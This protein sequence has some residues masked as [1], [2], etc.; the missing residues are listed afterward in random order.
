MVGIFAIAEM[1]QYNTIQ[2][3]IQRKRKVNGNLIANPITIV[4]HFC[5]GPTATIANDEKH[6]LPATV[7]CE[8]QQIDRFRHEENE[9]NIADNQ[10]MKM[11]Q[12]CGNLGDYVIEN[13][14]IAL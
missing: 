4:D 14:K 11:L 3:C 8:N 10:L 12:N 1:L 2:L 9:N 6:V 13:F 5:L 7:G